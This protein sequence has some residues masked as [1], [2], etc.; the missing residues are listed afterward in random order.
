MA[1]LESVVSVQAR[2]AS[3]FFFLA[4]PAF[5]RV[6]K[7]ESFQS[8]RGRSWPRFRTGN[9]F[10]SRYA[11]VRSCLLFGFMQVFGPK[12]IEYILNIY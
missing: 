1:N 10:V 4:K 12:V 6:Q 5:S 11:N 9:F 8:P 7:F 3:V 2:D